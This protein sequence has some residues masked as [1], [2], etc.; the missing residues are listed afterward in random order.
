MPQFSPIYYYRTAMIMITLTALLKPNTLHSQV[1]IEFKGGS[2]SV[3]RLAGGDEFNGTELDHSKWLTSYPWARH[4]Y[5]SMDVNYYSDGEDL[6]L[7]SGHLN[8]T[9]RKSTI[10]AKAIPYES[11]SFRL[12]C[13]FKP[14]VNNLM[15][16][17]YQ[18]GMI[19][20]KEKYTYGYFEIRFRTDISS[21][22]WPAFWLFGADNQ[23]IDVFEMGGSRNSE[24]HVDI[25]CKKGCKDYPVFLGMFKKNW[26][27]FLKTTAN[28]TDEFH[29]IGVHWEKDGI[30]W[31]L[32]GIPVAWWEGV[33]KDPLAVIANL[34]VTN[35]EGSFGG[36]VNES[37]P[38]PA[39]FEIDY[40]RIWQKTPSPEI[41]FTKPSENSSM[42]P[43]R[44]KQEKYQTSSLTKRKRPEYRRKA[45]KTHVQRISIHRSADRMLQIIYE[46]NKKEALRIQFKKPDNGLTLS[47]HDIGKGV[48]YIELPVT[49]PAKMLLVI[50]C[51]GQKTELP[52]EVL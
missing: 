42:T 8:I 2:S 30:T 6:M 24:F 48:H 22:L 32:D 28:W 23:E 15:D 11:D 37:T 25:H 1:M 3:Y 20:S 19:Y 7:Q 34:A 33:F 43:E 12:N 29:T 14:P 21:G 27:S 13:D 31:Y 35:K 5:C 47:S 40:L 26:G 9:A 4:L 51:D 52:V 44:M 39:S 46:G 10:R 36:A 45:L 38:F 16:F 17:A 18:S 49:I 50:E 41:K